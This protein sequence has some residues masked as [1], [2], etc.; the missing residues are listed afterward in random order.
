MLL[1]SEAGGL[2]EEKQFLG[3]GDFWDR[4]FELRMV[5]G[6]PGWMT[7]MLCWTRF[8]PQLKSRGING[9]CILDGCFS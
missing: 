1:S 2:R 4:I 8:A 5:L 6:N 7:A 3:K 9:Q